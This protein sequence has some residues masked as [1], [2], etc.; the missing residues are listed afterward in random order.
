MFSVIPDIYVRVSAIEEDKYSHDQTVGQRLEIYPCTVEECV[1]RT[2]P[3][4]EKYKGQH[5]TT[6]QSVILSNLSL[7]DTLTSRP[8]AAIKLN[9]QI[10]QLMT[11]LAG[12]WCT[13]VW[14]TLTN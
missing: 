14:A 6:V 8:P 3:E 10:F 12:V 11:Q 2:N 4:I 5:S 9:I 1:L 13:G 7:F